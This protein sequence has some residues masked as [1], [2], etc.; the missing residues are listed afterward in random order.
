V[1]C[2]RRRLLSRRE[3]QF[4]HYFAILGNHLYITRTDD[5]S[6]AEAIL[7]AALAMIKVNGG[8]DFKVGKLRI[9]L[10]TEVFDKNIKDLF[11]ALI[12]RE[13]RLLKTSENLL[14]WI[15]E[16]DRHSVAMAPK[17]ENREKIRILLWQFKD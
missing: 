2:S 7:E 15:D 4:G 9:E 12:L 6:I 8:P 1:S 5:N 11:I 3:D 16:D 17:S 14:I 13:G 10:Q